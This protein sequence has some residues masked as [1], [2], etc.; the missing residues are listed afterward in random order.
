MMHECLRFDEAITHC[1][2]FVTSSYKYKGSK[3][4]ET[5]V[6]C[7]W[8]YLQFAF[9]KNLQPGG[10]HNLKKALKEGLGLFAYSAIKSPLYHQSEKNKKIRK[11][12][13]T[14]VRQFHKH[15]VMEA[16][17]SP[18]VQHNV[19]HIRDTWLKT[20]SIRKGGGG[21]GDWYHVRSSQSPG[22]SCGD[23]SSPKTSDLT[24]MRKEETG[25]KK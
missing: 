24:Q 19:S 25:E 12:P 22:G 2:R 7:E 14:H 21:K 6:R 11:F 4:R 13:C 17:K 9:I 5:E 18:F 3:P 23:H 8:T 16:F 1:L 10:I 15:E 20:I